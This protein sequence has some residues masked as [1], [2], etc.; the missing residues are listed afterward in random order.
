MQKPSFVTTVLVT[1]DEIGRLATSFNT[2]VTAIEE[3]EREIVHV[4]LHDGLSGLPNR[5]LFIEQ[6]AMALSQRR[7]NEHLL[8][9]Y[10]DLDDFKVVNDTLGHPAGDAL[11]KDVA[12]HT[13]DTLSDALIARLGGDESA[14]LMTGIKDEEN[15]GKMAQ[16]LER[17]FQRPVTVDGQQA[18]CSA[19]IG[20]A[21]APGD[22]IDG[23]TLMKNADLAFYCAKSEGKS[24]Y[25]FFEP[26]F[27]EQARVRRQT[28]LDLR[29]AL[30]EGGF[31]LVF[32]PLYCVAERRMTG[33][34][35]LLRWNHP[36]R[37][38]VSPAEFIPLAEETGLFLPIG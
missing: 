21:V 19:S 37:G 2:I 24:T 5:K 34:E 6:L 13:S 32:Q 18:D 29:L 27:H 20:I 35:A 30:K 1:D 17:C 26:S 8:V 25:Q 28:E 10:V 3:R 11:L 23:T 16:D 36:S 14:I 12:A 38:V 33:F 9:A 7:E 15:L 4:G 22:G 31:E